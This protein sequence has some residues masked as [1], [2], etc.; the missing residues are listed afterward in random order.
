VIH[1]NNRIIKSMVIIAILILSIVSVASASEGSHVLK[2]NA[3]RSTGFTA[4]YAVDTNVGSVT[5]VKGSWIVPNVYPSSKKDQYVCFW[6][7]IDGDTSDTIE[8][9]GTD[10]YVSKGIPQYTAW[11]EFYPK[12]YVPIPSNLMKIKPG[13][14]IS[15]EVKYDPIQNAFILSIND[16]DPSNP[17]NVQTFSTSPVKVKNAKRNSAEWITEAVSGVTLA[18]FDTVTFSSN[19]AKIDGNPYYL[20]S[21]TAKRINMV[22]NSGLPMATP[23]DLSSD[24]SF[25]VIWNSAGN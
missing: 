11:Y 3:K 6:V 5:D 15:A 8:Q 20:T 17:S 2:I 24:G 22:S 16:T 19:S 10:C 12:N 13:D 23:S 9:I 25:S 7:G 18:K 4:G 14:M 21:S 1:I